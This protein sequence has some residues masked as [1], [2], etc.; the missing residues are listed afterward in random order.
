M[1]NVREIAF[2]VCLAAGL[3]ATGAHA[4]AAPPNDP[5]LVAFF[6]RCARLPVWFNGHVS[7]LDDVVQNLLWQLSGEDRLRRADG[8]PFNGI[9]W[10]L[11]IA[12]GG[13]EWLD[14]PVLRVDHPDVAKLLNLTLPSDPS[15]PQFCTMRQ[16]LERLPALSAAQSEAGQGGGAPTP[17]EVALQRFTA[18][19][20][21]VRR[22]GAAARLPDLSDADAIR[23]AIVSAREA[24]TEPIPLLV[25][26]RTAGEPWWTLPYAVVV[27]QV[28]EQAGIAPNPATPHIDALL[29][30]WASADQPACN[31]ALDRYEQQLRDSGVAVGPYQFE[32]PAGWREL[33]I[34]PRGTPTFFSDV[35][36]HGWT[37]SRLER[38]SPDGLLTLNVSTFGGAT[39]PAGR[40]I[41]DWR[42]SEGLAPIAAADSDARKV[43][44]AGG[45]GWQAT[46]SGQDADT[47]AAVELVGVVFVRDGRTWVATYRGPPALVAAQR[48]DFDRWLASVQIGDAA[49]LSHWFPVD[50]AQTDPQPGDYHLLSAV[51]ETPQQAWVLQT[52]LLADEGPDDRATELRSL[53]ASLTEGETMVAV[54]EAPEPL[55]LPWSWTLPAG[56]TAAPGTANEI[57]QTATARTPIGWRI[58]RLKRSAPLEIELLVD[59]LR[60][61]HRL[62]PLTEADR[63]AVLQSIDTPIGRT[64]LIRFHVPPAAADAPPAR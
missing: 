55:R 33:G 46:I 7:N 1:R 48:A 19:L 56:W 12:S 30:A 34:P 50:A 61:T 42:M 26:P 9:A 28:G 23:H 35:L 15:Q 38:E 6:R 36:A 16:V 18:R 31:A 53:L 27:S 52:A 11:D 62:E 45:P 8:S 32:T 4:V 43:E 47:G 20:A 13:S 63:P 17:G 25:P 24:E 14:E 44:V 29:R 21:V 40:I 39:A 54:S 10:F 41:N 58:Q 64:W 2:W 3:G 5:E 49:Q 59:H 51:I 37:A 60:S 22:L 57:L